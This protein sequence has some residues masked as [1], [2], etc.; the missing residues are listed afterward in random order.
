MIED[1]TL[2]GNEYARRELAGGYKQRLAMA[3]GL[4]HEP[5][6]SFFG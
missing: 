5:A 2:S 4:L 3:V 6:H 1:F